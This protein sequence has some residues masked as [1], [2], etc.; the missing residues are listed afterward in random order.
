MQSNASLMQN[1]SFWRRCLSVP[2]TST[3]TELLYTRRHSRH[4]YIHDMYKEQLFRV[5]Y[6]V[7]NYMYMGLVCLQLC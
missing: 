3:P 1:L 5:G 4:V 6:R 2:Q 7:H